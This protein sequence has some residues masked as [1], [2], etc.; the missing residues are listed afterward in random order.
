M[1]ASVADSFAPRFAARSMR[2]MAGRAK[3]R[4][5][6]VDFC[7]FSLETVRSRTARAL[8]SR[9]FIDSTSSA[10]PSSS[11]AGGIESSSTRVSEAIRARRE[12]RV[13]PGRRVQKTSYVLSSTAYSKSSRQA[14]ASCWL[15]WR[16]FVMS[17]SIFWEASELGRAHCRGGQGPHLLLTQRRPMLHMLCLQQVIAAR[18]VPAAEQ[19]QTPKRR[20]VRQ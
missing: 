16:N 7:S 4:N 15:S 9:L 3:N 6:L 13:M 2:R 14:S 5:R 18:D 10:P 19:T 17:S 8:L 20:Q 12:K 11:S 1:S